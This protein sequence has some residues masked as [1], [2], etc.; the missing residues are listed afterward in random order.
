MPRIKPLF[1]NNFIFMDS[2]IVNFTDKLCL[3]T[4]SILRKK[5]VESYLAAM[6][7]YCSITMSKTVLRQ[8]GPVYLALFFNLTHLG[9][10]T[11]FV[12]SLAP[13]DVV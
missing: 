2:F 10:P 4:L 12:V 3:V 7:R 6:N 11:V 8:T 1:L 9:Q 13:L 5:A